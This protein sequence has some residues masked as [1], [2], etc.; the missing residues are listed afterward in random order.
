VPLDDVR[1]GRRRAHHLLQHPL[2]RACPVR[3]L[4]VSIAL[5]SVLFTGL[6]IATDTEP[7][8]AHSAITAPSLS[9]CNWTGVRD[10]VLGIGNTTLVEHFNFKYFDHTWVYCKVKII[11][12]VVR[13]HAWVVSR[14]DGYTDHWGDTPC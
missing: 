9:V 5:V 7:A 1:P 13:C 14:H 10:G 6:G 4:I 12:T 8:S 3:R 2:Q 11:T